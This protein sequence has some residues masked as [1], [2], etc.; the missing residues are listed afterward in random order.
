MIVDLRHAA[1]A[2]LVIAGTGT[3]NAQTVITTQPAETVIAPAPLQLTPAQRTTIYRTIVPRGR[4][5][6]PIVHERVV[7]ETAPARIGRRPVAP[8]PGYVEE[9]TY[10]PAPRVVAPEETYGS[11]VYYEVGA[12]VPAT[13]R[14]APLPPRAIAANPALRPYRYMIFRD[15]VLL[16]DPATSIVVA[17]ITP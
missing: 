13:V 7:T 17:D 9:P 3:A 8:P 1:A 11:D 15:R 5:R 4:G 6:Q 14:L 16:V 10:V 2:L 12:R